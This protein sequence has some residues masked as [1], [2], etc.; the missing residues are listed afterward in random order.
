MAFVPVLAVLLTAVALY[1]SRGV[2][3]Q[4]V[5]P[6]GLV[7]VALLPPWQSVA[8]FAG[9]G[10]LGWLWLDRRAV[11]RASA[12]AVHPAIAPLLMPLF[13][14]LLL[15]IPYLPWL[16]DQVPALQILAGPARVVVW[17]VVA[18]QLVWVLWQQRFV[19]ADWLQR[20]TLG[21]LAI[22]ITVVTALLAG[23]ASMRFAGGELYPNGDEPHYLVMAQSLWRDGDL[24]IE[25]NHDRGDYREYFGRD[26]EPHFLTRGSDGE[27]YSIHPVGMPVLMAPIYAAGGYRGVVFAFVLIA[28]LAAGVMWHTVTQLANSAGAS[29]FAWAAIVATAPFLFNTFAVYPEIPAALAVAVAFHLIATSTASQPGRWLG[30]GVA[31]AALPWLSTKYAPMSAALV[32]IALAR[33]AFPGAQV[34][35]ARGARGAGAAPAAAVVIPYGASLLVWFYFFYAFWGSPL[36]QTVYGNLVQTDLK[37]LFFGA[38]GLLFDQEYGLLAYAPVYIL[39]ATGL[40]VMWRDS[41]TSR[42]LAIEVVIVFAALLGTVGAFRIWW[43]G[44]ASP[45]RPLTSGLLLLA[46]PIAFAFRAAPQASGRRAAQHLLLWVSVGMSGLLLF[47]ENGFL[48][49]NGRDGTSALLE[50]LVAPLAAVDDRAIL[51]SARGADGVDALRAL[52][53]PRGSRGG[54]DRPTAH[55]TRRIRGALGAWHHSRRNTGCDHR[56]ASPALQTGVAGPRCQGAKPGADTRRIRHDAPPRR[57]RVH[58][59]AVDAPE[60]RGDRRR[61]GGRGRASQG[62]TAPSCDPQ[63]PILAPCRK[64]PC[65]GGLERRTGWRDDWTATRPNRRTMAIVARRAEA[66]RALEP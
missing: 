3:D 7:R 43:G 8:A 66:R 41:P 18:A 42:R 47:A 26:L 65:R 33:L 27:I 16:P 22:G 39:A 55:D 24:R 32:A 52:A 15:V 59:P 25:N 2:L 38:P 63:R 53:P 37:N 54:G 19:T 35:G 34:Q 6:A 29:T 44:S 10:L 5:T 4:L 46:L 30:V 48:T 13:G 57:P 17:L 60:E 56:H 64:L 28:A 20:A 58:A 40:W 9:V 50:Y 12:T 49:A 31:A 61:A 11:P 1:L 36:P 45:G 14:L 21:Q 23:G 51:H 62:T